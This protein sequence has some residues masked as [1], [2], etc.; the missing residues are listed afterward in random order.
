VTKFILARNTIFSFFHTVLNFWFFCFK[1]KE[2]ESV[3][4]EAIAESISNHFSLKPLGFVIATGLRSPVSETAS[5]CFRIASP[6]LAT[7]PN[8][9]PY[10]ITGVCVNY[11]RTF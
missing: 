2:Q 6:S 4:S 11:Y 10:A 1:T 3:L 5:H 7:Q 8:D 9:V